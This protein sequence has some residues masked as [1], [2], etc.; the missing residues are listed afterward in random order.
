LGGFG[1]QVTDYHDL[2]RGAGNGG[3]D[4]EFAGASFGGEGF[5]GLSVEFCHFFIES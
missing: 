1:L 3:G 2:S 5:T 4:S